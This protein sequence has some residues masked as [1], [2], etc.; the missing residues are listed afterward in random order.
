MTGRHRELFKR[1]R[2]RTL[3]EQPSADG[4]TQGKLALNELR[5]VPFHP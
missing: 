2:P 1:G 5:L 3:D 4:G